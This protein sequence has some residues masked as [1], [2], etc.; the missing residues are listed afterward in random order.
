[1]KV[2]F[3]DLKAQLGPL[4][5]DIK[6]AVIEVVNST[7]Y[8]MG[9]KV[10]EFEARIAEYVGA[11]HGIGV[12]SG[13]DA[14]LASLMALDVG[15]GDLAITTPYS[16]FATAGA[17]A[18]LN[19]TPVF[20]DIDPA[21]Y[22]L[23]PGAL[24]EWLES[25][26]EKRAK[27][28]VIIPVHLYG[29]AADMDPILDVAREYG[30][31]VVEDAAQAI[32]TRYPSKEGQKKAGSMGAFGCFSFYPTKN[33]NGMGD[34]GM[35][36]TSDDGAAERLRMLRNH[37]SK[38]R[39]LHAL[40]G[41]NFRLDPIQAAVLLVKLEHLDA[42]NSKRQ[43]N[44]ARYDEHLE[45]AGVQTPTVAYARESHT[46]HQYVIRVPERR[47]ELRRYLAES[48]IASE[49]YYPVSFHEQECFSGLGYRRGDFPNSEAAADH[50]LA[51]PVHPELTREMQDYVIAKIEEFYR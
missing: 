22:N 34:G 36:V 23:S 42:W 45:A 5:A 19:A 12:S 13:T 49:I 18:R 11:K 50:T 37:G 48:D 15:P 14:L 8:I 28:K 32:G 7:R 44:A 10:E 30:I 51:L 16:F 41:G 24:R 27:V 47:D 39:Y 4:E 38:T 20:I 33:L 17:V 31:P 3:L 26:P 25:N 40:V 43:D 6:A 21:T 2:P 1:M 9:P 46:Y 35:V 29:Q